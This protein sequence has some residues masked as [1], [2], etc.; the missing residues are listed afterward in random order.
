MPLE[1]LSACSIEKDGSHRYIDDLL[2]LDAQRP[3]DNVAEV[4]TFGVQSYL[5]IHTLLM[6]SAWASN[7]ASHFDPCFA[8]Y[9]IKGISHG[10]RIGFAH[11]AYASFSSSKRNMHSA[12]VNSSTV[13][14]YIAAELEKGRLLGPIPITILLLPQ[15]ISVL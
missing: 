10:F 1:A 14:N 3:A 11:S 15:F 7:L 9:I 8:A 6:A 13:D 5:D 2:H 4:S 12:Y